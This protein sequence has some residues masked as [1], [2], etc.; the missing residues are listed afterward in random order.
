LLSALVPAQ[1]ADQHRPVRPI[2]LAVDQELGE[3]ARLGV[4]PV[5]ADPVGPLGV[6]EHQDMEQLGAGNWA[7]GV[8][9]LT[10]GLFE[11]L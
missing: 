3:G 11:L 2:F 7:E 4:P 8:E 6:R 9:L 5:G 10:H 1:H